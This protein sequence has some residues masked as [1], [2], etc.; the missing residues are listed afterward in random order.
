M[1]A[2]DLPYSLNVG[3]V[4]YE[5]REDF[6]AV[7]DILTAFSDDELNEKEKTQAMIE[8]L[9]YPVLPP[10]EA[11]EEAA[12]AARWFI[13]CGITREEEQPTARTMDWE[14]DAGII[15]PAVNKIAGFETRGRQTIHW[16][17]FYGWFMEIDDGLFSQV[18]SIRQKLAKG[19]KL[20]KWEQEFLRNNQKLCKLKGAAN[21]TQGDYEFFAELF[22]RG[23]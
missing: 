3:G 20:E 7:L 18:L 6:R 19:K 10:P 11:L 12:E 4:D 15:F 5:I 13:D 22:G 9:Y 23:E 14:Q 17:T 1:A 21:G 8:I 2:W 16:W